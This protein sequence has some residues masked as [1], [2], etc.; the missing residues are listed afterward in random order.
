MCVEVVRHEGQDDAV[1]SIGD[2]HV[3]DVTLDERR[4]RCSPTGTIQH[5]RQGVDGDDV[6]ARGDE[7]RSHLPGPATELEDS[8]TGRDLERV[9][10]V[11]THPPAAACRQEQGGV[12]RVVRG[13]AR[14]MR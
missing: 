10:E 3:E 12:Q 2:L 6:C 14:V 13:G 4:A 9:D 1:E 5:A 7:E 11:L 8:V